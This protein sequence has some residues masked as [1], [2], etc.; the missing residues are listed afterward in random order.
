[1]EFNDIN[2][3]SDLLEANEAK[4]EVET[5]KESIHKLIGDKIEETS[6]VSIALEIAT[7]LV[8]RLESFHE[9][10][11]ESKIENDEAESSLAWAND[12]GKLNV[13]WNILKSIEL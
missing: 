1:M 9:A 11:A 7:E 6:Q 12:S 4:T 2:T 3:V 13:A 8:S 10:I 5:F